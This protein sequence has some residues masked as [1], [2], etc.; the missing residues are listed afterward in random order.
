M[1]F[2]ALD[3][4][5]VSLDRLFQKISLARKQKSFSKSPKSGQAILDSKSDEM[6]R[7]KSEAVVLKLAALTEDM[8]LLHLVVPQVKLIESK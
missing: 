2:L 6:R 8:A 5:L 1:K 7:W 4:T 3:V